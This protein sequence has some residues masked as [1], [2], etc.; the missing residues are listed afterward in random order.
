[1][2]KDKMRESFMKNKK[3]LVIII[4]AVMLVILSICIGTGVF[5]K[6]NDAKKIAEALKPLLEAKS[7]SMNLK[8]DADINRTGILLDSNISLIQENEVKYL[9]L[10]QEGNVFY[11]ADNV[12]FLK[13]GKAFKIADEMQSQAVSYENLL[14]QI[15]ELYEILEI[16]A[17]ETE[18]EKS[19]EISVTGEQVQ[20]LLKAVP[21]M[22]ETD[23]SMIE[24]LQV[25]LVTKEAVLDR[26]ELFGKADMENVAAEIRITASD[27]E[28]LEDGESII[29]DAVKASVATVDKE[30][31]FSLTEDL[32]RLVLALEPFA[33][34]ENLQGTLKLSVNCG[35]LQTNV[36]LKLSELK[37]QTGN[38]GMEINAADLEALPEILGM[39]CMEGDISCTENNG[40]YSYKLIL[41]KDT[42]KKLV[43]MLIPSVGIDTISFTKGSTEILLT[44]NQ[45]MQMEL[46]IEGGI[47]AMITE[48]PMNIGV[49]FLFE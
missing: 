18:H 16:T 23:L 12:L 5:S 22:A 45:I 37:N 27:F 13:N 31:L 26:I 9:V 2:L 46:L 4:A 33:N 7:Q 14:P 8:I 11:I 15:L 28:I 38:S 43:E 1:M 36:S 35:L 40:V 49:T 20:M 47:N 3:R 24:N 17:V 29:P 34:M 21:S 30:A 10:E 42:M 39:L 44:E 19:Y 25:K 41:D 6:V 32:Y 48:V